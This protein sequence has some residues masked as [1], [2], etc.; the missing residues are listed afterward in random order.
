MT[1]T[2]AETVEVK[3]GPTQKKEATGH[4][5]C[6]KCGL[7]VFKTVAKQKGV[8]VLVACR[9]CGEQRD[10]GMNPAIEETPVPAEAAVVAEAVPE[11]AVTAEVPVE[12][13]VKVEGEAK[14]EG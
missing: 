7:R 5:P 1:D 8:K 4:P 14:S 9:G 13:E 3:K 11:V 2:V 6:T 10:L 12:A